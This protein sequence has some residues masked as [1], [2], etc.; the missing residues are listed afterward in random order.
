MA[1]FANQVAEGI[2]IN[3]LPFGRKDFFHRP[4]LQ[5]FPDLLV[6][7]GKGA[8]VI[9]EEAVGILPGALHLSAAQAGLSR[10]CQDL[11]QQGVEIFPVLG[12]MGKSPGAVVR[13][14]AQDDRH[15][16]HRHLHAHRGGVSQPNIGD[17][18]DI[19]GIDR[20]QGF[21]Q[22]DVGRD[23]G[24]SS[25]DYLGH[26]RP[27]GIA[28]ARMDADHQLHISARHKGLGGAL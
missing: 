3:G 25:R 19:V 17:L 2:A 23:F 18:D 10:V 15:A 4:G 11:I 14:A 12:I 27:L 24:Q 26:G 1:G 9:E 5:L 8:G 6:V 20:V 7:P 28:F 21:D 22:V 13:A 16:A